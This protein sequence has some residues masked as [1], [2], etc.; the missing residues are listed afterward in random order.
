MA[1]DGWLSYHRCVD[2]PR[3]N[4]QKH[5]QLHVDDGKPVAPGE[6]ELVRGFLSLHDHLPGDENSLPPSPASLETWFRSHGLLAD[7]ES[8]SPEELSL[9]AQVARALRARLEGVDEPP[10]SDRPAQ[11]DQIADEAGLRVSFQPIGG[12]G[13]V[14]LTATR[15]GLKGALARLLG[16]AFLAELDGTWEHLKDCSNP[17]CMGVFFDTSKNHSGKWCSMA[18]CGNRAKVRAFRERRAAAP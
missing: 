12:R 7:D 16:I 14:G 17:T 2:T 13:K 11:L 9:A 8:P 15:D 3:P 1:I 4:T 10:G 5:P 18:S 6:L